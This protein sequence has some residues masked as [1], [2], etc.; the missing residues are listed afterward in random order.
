MQ[1]QFAQLL[2]DQ[3]TQAEKLVERHLPGLDGKVLNKFHLPL[4]GMS[5]EE[6]AKE[7]EAI[8][9]SAVQLNE[10]AEAL[11]VAAVSNTDKEELRKLKEEYR[12]IYMAR[13]K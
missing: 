12:K 1:R 8:R 5:K 4:V 9:Q 3:K 7:A 11:D 2:V 10:M 6:R 13:P